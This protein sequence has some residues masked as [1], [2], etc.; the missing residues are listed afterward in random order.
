MSLP[1]DDTF[2]S[3]S[4][5]HLEIYSCSLCG[6]SSHRELY[7]QTISGGSTISPDDFNCTNPGHGEHFRIVSCNDC[8]MVYCSPRPAPEALAMLY[9][10]GEDPTYVHEQDGRVRTFDASL[11]R[12]GAIS[13][14]LLDIGCQTG[15][16]MDRAQ[17]RGM[18]VYGLEPSSYATKLAQQAGRKVICGVAPCSLPWGKKFDVI[19]L[20]DVIEHVHDPLEIL[21]FCFDNLNPGGQLHLSTMYLDSW[22]VRL[23]G[24]KWPWF[25]RMHIQY[26]TRKS[27]T[28]ALTAVGF[29]D[30]RIRAHKHIVHRGY[31]LQKLAK[32]SW[33]LRL[34][35]RLGAWFLADRD[36]YI[37]V[38]MGDMMHVC[39][40][41]KA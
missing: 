39:G 5:A 16:F 40:V 29:T 20:W 37:P 9:G 30:I 1:A 41:R 36:G 6:S 26:F 31:L 23:V 15:I 33:P 7:P 22:Y 38:S 34:V 3:S 18:D 14:S 35:G 11:D 32:L 25:M 27:I 19:T 17:R 2:Q 4:V 10:E 28:Q 8:G 24:R 21:K 13:G 12:M